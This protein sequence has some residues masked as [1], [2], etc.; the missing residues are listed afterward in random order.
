M[1][2]LNQNIIVFEDDTFTLEFEV[3]VFEF[4]DT[5]N[6]EA[7]D[8]VWF[9]IATQPGNSY[10]LQKANQ[11]DFGLYGGS[12]ND[13]TNVT[14]FNNGLPQDGVPMDP[15][16]YGF[17]VPTSGESE[18]DGSGQGAYISLTIN[19]L[20]ENFLSSFSPS[21]ASLGVSNYSGGTGFAS[22]DT[23]TIYASNFQDENSNFATQDLII[24]LDDTTQ[25][26]PNDPLP[27]YTGG[28]IEIIAPDGPNGPCKVKVYFD[29]SD[30]AQSS[31]P[32][33]TGETYYWEL[34][35]GELDTYSRN[36]VGID[37]DPAYET[38]V[39]ATGYMHVSESIFS[40]EEYRP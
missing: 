6:I 1:G 25:P 9:G 5:F 31:G 16:T 35:V 10:I 26:L 23:I 15:Q 27:Q 14:D 29:Q 11:W 36:D 18:T 4:N 22:G 8:Q 30:F 21:I 32:L 38:Q 40:I 19:Y 20:G 17:F 28:D 33:V 13:L 12:V 39:V 3:D 34:V 37:G 2:N 7:T 24:T